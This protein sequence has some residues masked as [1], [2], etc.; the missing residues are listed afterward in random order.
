MGKAYI[1]Q[2]KPT[3]RLCV[4]KVY[5]K[6]VFI[7]RSMDPNTLIQYLKNYLNYPSL[8][9]E[10]LCVFYKADKMT[11]IYEYLPGGN[12]KGYIARGENV[13]EESAKYYMARLALGL[14]AL[15]KKDI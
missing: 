13:S 1:T 10:L 8:F 3:K 11:F 12:L 9:I 14:E 5:E 4:M 2:Y 15:H 7:E 6:K